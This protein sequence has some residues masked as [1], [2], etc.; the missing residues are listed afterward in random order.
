MEK[1]EK[2]QKKSI[3][4]DISDGVVVLG[5]RGSGKSTLCRYLISSLKYRFVVIDVVGNFSYLKDNEKVEY[6]LINPH[7][8]ETID[9]ICRNTMSE[10]NK[11]LVLDEADRLS[12]STML[13][14][15]L[16]L[17][18]NYGV[19][20]IATARRTANIHKDYLANQKHAFIFKHTYPRDVKVLEEWLNV[21][22]ELLRNV[23]PYKPLYFY[24]DEL[25]STF[26]YSGVKK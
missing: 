12:Y 15:T 6:H 24:E 18:R 4:I 5:K 1:D 11:M 22:S 16:N 19:G 21:E 3:K 8:T 9:E 25:K 26:N 7:S 10:G 14:D 17:G 13:S 23:Q 20:Y 2:I